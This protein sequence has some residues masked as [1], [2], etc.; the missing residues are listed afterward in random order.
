MVQDGE[1]SSERDKRGVSR[2]MP[3]V[4]QSSREGMLSPPLRIDFARARGR[5]RCRR[6]RRHGSGRVGRRRFDG[7][8]WQRRGRRRGRRMRAVEL[9]KKSGLEAWEEAG[10]HGGAAREED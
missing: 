9:G 8:C 7:C 1:V 5:R 6:V 3:Q 10:E 4:V 2:R